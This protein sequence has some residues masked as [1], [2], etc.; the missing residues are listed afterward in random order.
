M[1]L[2]VAVAEYKKQL[3]VRGYAQSTIDAYTHNLNLFKRYLQDKQLFDLRKVTH[4]VIVEYQQ[5]VVAEP[6]SMESKA[7][8]IRPVKRLFEYLTQTHR[9]LINPTEG[10][11]ETCRKN[12]KP[13]MV[14]SVNE[15]KKLLDQPNLSLR[16]HLRN[17]AIIEILYATGIRLNE[18]VSL[19]VYHVDLKDKVLHIQ[20]KGRKQRVV[21]MGKRAAGYLKEYLEKIRPWWARRNPKERSLFLNHHGQ[22]LTRDS[23]QA[24]IRKYRLSA[25][26]KKPVSPHTFRRSCATHMLQQGADIRYIQKL[27]GHRH[28][29]TTQIYTKVVPT[30]V[31][32]THNKTHPGVKGARHKAKGPGLKKDESH[33]N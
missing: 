1:D 5:K 26:I 22:P 23:V 33:E 7:H 12:R 16:P 15:M 3:K 21:P 28:L 4:Q 18:L 8:K 32:A 27:L 20:G 24:F 9:L 25:G 17:K 19:Q 14:I 6:I 10:I 30:E 2:F 13:G 31:K 11:V 29:S